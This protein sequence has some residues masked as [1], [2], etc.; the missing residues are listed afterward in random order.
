VKKRRVAA[1]KI[2]RRPVT[3]ERSLSLDGDTITNLRGKQEEIRQRATQM[4]HLLQVTHDA[5][6]RI[7]LLMHIDDLK[8]AI[9][10]VE[11]QILALQHAAAIGVCV[12]E[13][14]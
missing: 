6:Q 11:K 13:F 9:T 8:L 4:G 5:K 7:N 12:L 14:V 2:S 10:R 3:G 1:I